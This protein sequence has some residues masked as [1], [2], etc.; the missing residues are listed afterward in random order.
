MLK[1]AFTEEEHKKS[2]RLT[3]RMFTRGQIS[4]DLRGFGPP[5]FYLSFSVK[6]SLTTANLNSE[7]MANLEVRGALL[8]PQKI[9]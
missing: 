4:G 2:G 8:G 9:L 1:A 5:L 3:V 7:F 6:I